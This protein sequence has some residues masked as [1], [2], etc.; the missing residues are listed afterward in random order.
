MQNSAKLSSFQ[1]KFPFIFLIFF[2]SRFQIVSVLQ[3][4]WC[5]VFA[6]KQ[7]T[8][9]HFIESNYRNCPK[10]DYNIK[11]IQYSCMVTILKQFTL[12]TTIWNWPKWIKKKNCLYTT[13]CSIE[14]HNFFF[15]YHH[16]YGCHCVCMRDGTKCHCIHTVCSSSR[17]KTKNYSARKHIH[18]KS[19]LPDAIP[20]V[21]EFDRKIPLIRPHS[22]YL[23]LYRPT[24]QFDGSFSIFMSTGFF[25]SFKLK[26]MERKKT[27]TKLICLLHS[28]YFFLKF[29]ISSIFI[30]SIQYFI[31][32]AFKAV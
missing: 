4:V 16:R 31:S 11:Q 23:R 18:I 12:K 7:T 22:K 27:P 6:I 26:A 2:S 3:Y 28:I 10:L 29:Y 17:V 24:I 25:S 13:N 5:V 32:D 15:F 21:F 30:R 20:M 9:K 19:S 8:H 14:T 1:L